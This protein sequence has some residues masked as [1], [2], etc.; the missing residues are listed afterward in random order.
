MNAV[1]IVRFVTLTSGNGFADS[2]ANADKS[3]LNSPP[4]VLTCASVNHFNIAKA[5]WHMKTEL[6]GG[7]AGQVPPAGIQS[8]GIWNSNGDFSNTGSTT[9]GTA[10]ESLIENEYVHSSLTVAD[11]AGLSLRN[12]WN[13]F[14]RC[15]HSGRTCAVPVGIFGISTSESVVRMGVS[16]LANC[17]TGVA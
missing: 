1:P 6:S 17:T 2:L 3:I 10:S 11:F 7:T 8:P 15:C 5:S 4:R 13:N 12:A 9:F 14:W 16:E